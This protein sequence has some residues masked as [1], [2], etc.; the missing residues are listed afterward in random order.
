MKATSYVHA[1]VLP[2]TMTEDHDHAQVHPQAISWSKN[3]FICY[4]EDPARGHNL[5]MTFIE[6]INGTDWQIAPPHELTIKPLENSAVPNLHMMEWSNLLTDLAILDEFGNFYVLLA[7]VGLL[8]PRKKVEKDRALDKALDNGTHKV[9]DEPGASKEKSRGSDANPDAKADDGPLY[10]LT[11][12]NHIEMIYRDIRPATGGGHGPGVAFRWLGIEKPQIVNQGAHLSADAKSY[13]YGV[14]LHQAT[15]AA[16]PIITK[17]ACVVV[18]RDGSVVLYY[19]G[20]H[21][22]EYH[23]MEVSLAPATGTSMYLTHASVGFTFDKKICITCLDAVSD[24]IYC[25]LISIDWGFLTELAVRQRTDPHYH[26]PPEKQNAP[27]ITVDLI[28]E[29]KPM[30]R[31]QG[32][33]SGNDKGERPDFSA[34]V[35]GSVAL[36]T[37]VAIDSLSPSHEAGLELHVMV[38]YELVDE[39]RQVS[40]VVQRFTVKD[41]RDMLSSPFAGKESSKSVF[42]LEFQDSMHV[43]RKL[44]AIKTALGETIVLLVHEDGTVM[45]IS[46]R[47]WSVIGEDAHNNETPQV[48][49]S[50][51]QCGFQFPRLPVTGPYL[52]AVSP[53]MTCVV[54]SPVGGQLEMAVLQSRM[55]DTEEGDKGQEGNDSQDKDAGKSEAG[56][57]E[58]GKTEAQISTVDGQMSAKKELL[59]AVAYSHTHAHAC[60]SNLCLDD[61]LALIKEEYYRMKDSKARTQ[62]MRHVLTEL[63]CAINFQLNSFGKESVDKLL[64]N[65]PLQKLLS[66][67]LVLSNLTGMRMAGDIAWIVLNLRSTSFG[68][69]FSL[70]SIYRQISKKKPANDTHADSVLRAECIVSLIGNVKWLIDLIIYL[71]QE[72]LQLWYSRSNPQDLAVSTENSIALPIILSKVPRLFLMYALSSIG[73]TQEI[74]KKLH[75]DLTDSNKLYVPMKEALERFFSTCSLTPLKLSV[76]EA[77]LRECESQIA[78]APDCI[79]NKKDTLLE[80]ERRLLCFGEVPE[81]LK[82]MAFLIVDRHMAVFSRDPRLSDLYFY[83]NRWID[84]GVA[85]KRPRLDSQLQGHEGSKT[86]STIIRFRYSRTEAIDALRKIFISCGPTISCSGSASLGK[87]YTSNNKIR[88]CVRCRSISLV[89]DPLVFESSNAIGLWTMVFQRTCICGSAWVNC[90]SSA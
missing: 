19:Q 8:R 41:V 20:E 90:E 29:M 7:G 34:K 85:R 68:I 64:S 4:A 62:L 23:K 16:H 18:R 71:N 52:F 15:L 27:K 78:K 54:Y 25:Y 86:S 38:S 89:S 56:K 58:A 65:P 30:P 82:K 60:Y 79:L 48:V 63:H 88:K 44:K 84:V 11:S 70:S 50:I 14:Q 80:A 21:K 35:A 83:D 2:N 74:L 13:V 17:Q 66:F 1:K 5:K 42:L 36:W 26:T 10:E 31:A 76:F 55:G 75:K 45:P 33:A 12:Y 43:A 57:S 72:L 53:N 67:Q 69:M 37:L 51:L 3:G 22:V 47:T 32:S 87:G 9:K 59:V 49:E 81:P 6:N 77:F 73:K 39:K 40:Y 24:C 46:R 61:L 28:H